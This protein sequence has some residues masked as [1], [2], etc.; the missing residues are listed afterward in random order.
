MFPQIT[1]YVK[2][3]NDG[4]TITKTMSLNA[5]DKKPRVYQN[6]GKESIVY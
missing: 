3:F 4:K 6:I 5:T 2:H 1:G